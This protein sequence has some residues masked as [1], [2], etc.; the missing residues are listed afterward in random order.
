MNSLGL[1]EKSGV[2]LKPTGKSALTTENPV[3]VALFTS[4]EVSQEKIGPSGDVHRTHFHVELYNLV[5][6]LGETANVAD[7]HPERVAELRKQL[8]LWRETVAA[9]MPTPNPDYDPDNARGGAPRK[10]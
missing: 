3:E 2:V 5:D 9:Q 8:H 10:K 6:D 1:P 7:Q 4:L